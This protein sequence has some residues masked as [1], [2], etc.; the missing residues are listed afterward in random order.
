MSLRNY[1][2]NPSQRAP[3]TTEHAHSKRHNNTKTKPSSNYSCADS[4]AST[5]SRGLSALPI[6][7]TGDARSPAP[8]A[9]PSL[10]LF[11]GARD[12][13]SHVLVHLEEGGQVQRVN[14]DLNLLVGQR[15][16]QLAH[17]QV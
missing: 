8:V 13:V 11:L 14:V 15:R 3:R 5:T 9:T 12:A 10:R 6:L 4:R 7:F 16:R 2:G 1:V 17:M